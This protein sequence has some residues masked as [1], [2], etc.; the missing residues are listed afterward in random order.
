MTIQTGTITDDGAGPSGGFF[1]RGRTAR[2]KKRTRAVKAAELGFTPLEVMLEA[3]RMHYIA[4]VI[5]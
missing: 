3:M 2:K 5:V 1:G 4:G